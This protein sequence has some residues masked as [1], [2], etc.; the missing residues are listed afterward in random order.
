MWL[1]GIKTRP[2]LRFRKYITRKV[3]N[4]KRYCK[5]VDITDINFIEFCIYEYLD[6]KW[7]RDDVTGLFVRFSDYSFEEIKAI[8][9][10]NDKSKLFVIVTEVAKYVSECI[11]NRKLDL[12]PIKY[13]IRI[14]GMN[15][16]ER[17]IGVEEPLHQIFDYVAVEGMRSLFYAKIGVFQ[18]ASLPGKGQ[19]YG[20]KH[21]ERWVKEKKT[22][23]FVKG[24]IK[25]CFPSIPHKRLKELLK[26]DIK[27]D[28]ILWLVYELIDMFGKAYKIR[29]GDRK[30]KTYRFV[31]ATD[32]GLSIGSYLSQYLSNYYLSYAYHYASE[33]LFKIRKTKRNGNTMV[34]LINHVLFYMDDFL[35]TG[36]AKKDLKKAM[37]MIIKYMYEFLEL[38]VK[39]NWKICKVSDAEPIDMMGFVFR[40]T[41]TTIRTAIFLKTRRYFL[42]ARKL[43]KQGLWISEKLA[44]QCVS[45]FGWFKNT[46]SYK[47]RIKLKIDEIHAICRRLISYYTKL[48][49]GELNAVVV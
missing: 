42:K 4:I 1:V 45:G 48:K 6:E 7:S 19:S 35:L 44:Y 8:T 30:S 10:N 18:C 20:K 2:P 17:V 32:K 29:V 14:D 13:Y 36:S 37:K 40:K 46:D 34:R 23:Y 24:D 27:N 41:K 28:N 49:R 47:I 16:K 5:D 11:K 15:K 33:R 21:V 12:K 25:K 39:P 9:S 22:T 43:L 31:E 38:V 3:I 26:R